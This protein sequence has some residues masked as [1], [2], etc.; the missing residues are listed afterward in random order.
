MKSFEECLVAAVVCSDEGWPIFAARFSGM[1][2]NYCSSEMQSLAGNAFPGTILISLVAA[3]VFS[4]DWSSGTEDTFTDG[5]AVQDALR[6]LQ[7]AS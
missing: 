3:L 2:E 7:S 6:L 1:I 4:C 5:A